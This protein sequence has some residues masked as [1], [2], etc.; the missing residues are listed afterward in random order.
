MG[1]VW[2]RLG[3]KVTV[4]EYLDRIVPG[5]DGEIAGQFQKLLRRQGLV[6]RLAS[7]VTAVTP[8]EDGV[9]VTLEPAGGGSAET[10]T[11]EIVLVSVG[12]KPFTEGLGLAEAGVA[13]DDKGRIKVDGRF[14]TSQPGI[15]AIGDCVAGAMLA[16]KAEDEGIA[17]AET[18]AGGAGHVN[19][20]VIPGVVYTNPEAASV[21]KT[22]EE[23]QDAGVDYVAGRFPMIANSRART[24][25]ET[26]GMV[27]VLAD[28]ST[29]HI[30]GTAAG[31]LIAEAAVAMEF[32]AS[33]EDL[34]RTCHAHPTFSE[35]VREAALAVDGRAI[36]A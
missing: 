4:I 29:V 24:Y 34:A 32:G 14:A 16:H 26:A 3:T 6:F 7:Q 35:A 28:R 31:E 18:L 12:R 21:G 5:M 8:G 11:T 17:V 23:L 27:K 10:L 9:D 25:D 20:D 36:H 2:R 1:S 13:T 15:H 19:H 22:E 30:L 33:S